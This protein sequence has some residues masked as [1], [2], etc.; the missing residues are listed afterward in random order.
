MHDLLNEILEKYPAA[1]AGSSFGGQHEIRNL[2]ERLK[3][4][5]ASLDFVKNNKNLLVKY[6]YGKGNWAETPWIA[7]LDIRE[8]TSTQNGT[9]VVILFRADGDGCHLKLG[10][11]VTEIKELYGS[12]IAATEELQRRAEKV[13]TMFPKMLNT[14][15]DSAPIESNEKRATLTNMY[16][17]STIYSKY[18][19]R[20]EIP[21][22]EELAGD[23]QQL[24]DCY[25]QYVDQRLAGLNPDDA[26]D[27]RKIWAIAL[28]EGGRL[29]NESYEKGII[30]I[31]WDE[32]GDLSKYDS[33]DAIGTKL[34]E[35]KG[36]VG[37]FPRNDSLCC[38][39][40]SHEMKV[41]DLV[42]AKVGRK[43]VIGGGII[44]SDYIFDPERREHKSIRRV[45]WVTTQKAEFPGTGITT[46]T[47]TE[48]SRYPT[49]KDMA[50]SYIADKTVVVR[51][52]SEPYGYEDA[53]KD[54]FL[55]RSELE[56][57]VGAT[58]RKKNI[59]L[60]GPPGV[61]KTFVSKRLAYLI[62]GEKDPSRVEFI[63]F[64]QSYSYEDFVQGWRPNSTGGF[65][66]KNGSFYNFCEKARSD[67]GRPYV[68]IIDEINRGNLSKIFG[69]LLMLIEG[70]KRGIDNAIKLTYSESEAERFS[71]P[72]NVF[73]I[74]LMNT[75]D[76]SLALVDYALRRRFAFF[77]L[78]PQLDSDRFQQA[79]TKAGGTM[80]LVKKIRN[81]IGSLNQ[82]ISGER[83][84][85]GP[86]FQIGHS[87]FCPTETITSEDEWYANVIK[88]EIK[89]L[90]EE[91]WFDAPEK[92]D[93]LTAQLLQ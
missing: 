64:H 80:E 40:F 90:I 51:V 47:L 87:Y 4:E 54:L 73:L 67:L 59:I 60:Q 86:G 68:F 18:Y 50:E 35:L 11:G 2:F 49:F 88:A 21:S 30:S 91:Y 85:L 55:S 17:A 74:G 78:A 12:G 81:R 44:V 8:T 16:E 77:S 83:R 48:I 5:I 38:Y 36:D 66:L 79:I 32:L 29:W 26:D 24:T 93:T 76:R 10:Q 52:A 6:S 37:P 13:R 33:Q 45:N 7:I 25:E 43:K 61:G 41:G 15:F 89:P 63:Q 23:I 34:F 58:K 9:Y 53:L 92:A 57:I 62:M 65:N 69:E 20:E 31:G 28:G 14:A 22:N 84:D 72:E 3:G 56:E 39:E 71:V 46:K 70:D 75:A 19:K 27:G 1:R 42:L 82:V